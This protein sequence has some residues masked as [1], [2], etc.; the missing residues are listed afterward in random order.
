MLTQEQRALMIKMRDAAD[1]IARGANAVTEEQL[2][3]EMEQAAA[4]LR[5]LS[6]KRKVAVS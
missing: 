6:T 1:Q 4:Q 3:Q 2:I 5:A